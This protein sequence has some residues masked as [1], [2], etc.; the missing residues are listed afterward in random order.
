MKN[1]GSEIASRFT[2]ENGSL[3]DTQ[4]NMASNLLGNTSLR[5]LTSGTKSYLYCFNLQIYKFLVF[6]F[7]LI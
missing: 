3:I 1:I 4:I 5:T 2:F 6:Y 7:Y